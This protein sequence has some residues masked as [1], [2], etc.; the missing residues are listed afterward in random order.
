[1]PAIRDAV[2]P[3]LELARDTKIIHRCADDEDVSAK[4]LVEHVAATLV[5]NPDRT[6][7]RIRRSDG[8]EAL[9]VKVR[10]R[11]GVEVTS[12]HFETW[13]CRF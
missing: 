5:C 6:R 3:C 4:E 13:D 7:R 11:I 10:D 12:D 9:A 1:M 8:W 2:D